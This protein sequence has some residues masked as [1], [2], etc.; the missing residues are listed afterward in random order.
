M[1]EDPHFGFV[2]AAYSFGFILLAGLTSSIV[3][4]RI[5]LERALARLRRQTDGSVQKEQLISSA[6]SRQ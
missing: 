3:I 2:V 4:D 5:Q 6:E 1:I